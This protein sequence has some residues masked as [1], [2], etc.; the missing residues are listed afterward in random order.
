MKSL[1]ANNG[2]GWTLTS[3]KHQTSMYPTVFPN[4]VEISTFGDRMIRKIFNNH[5]TTVLVGADSIV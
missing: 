2:P 3:L 5:N 1:D 4:K